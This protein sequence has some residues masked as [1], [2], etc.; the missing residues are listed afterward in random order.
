MKIY[1]RPSPFQ[2]FF[3][4]RWC[5]NYIPCLAQPIDRCLINKHPWWK[6]TSA[7][8]SFPQMQCWNVRF[9]GECKCGINN[10]PFAELWLGGFCNST[11]YWGKGVHDTKMACFYYGCLFIRHRKEVFEA[12]SYPSVLILSVRVVRD[13]FSGFA[14][15]CFMLHVQEIGEADT[16]A[17]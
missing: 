14:D 2:T 9:P 13:T 6:S 3:C 16:R 15:T 7:R 1:I 5:V 11:L 10:H 17:C 8:P 12:L 4:R